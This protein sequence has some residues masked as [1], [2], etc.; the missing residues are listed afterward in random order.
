MKHIYN[1]IIFPLCIMLF[2]SFAFSKEFPKGVKLV[3]DGNSYIVEYS[4]PEYKTSSIKGGNENFTLLEIP[5]YGIT[6]KVGLPQLPQISFFLLIGKNE[7]TPRIN[8]TG[9][10]KNSTGLKS[11]IYPVQMPWEKTRSLEDRPFVID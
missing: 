6:S 9:Q 3:K 2:S 8:I 5:E 1:F 11:L 4:I 7:S 10:T